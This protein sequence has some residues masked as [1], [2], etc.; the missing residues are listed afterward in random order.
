MC[1]HTSYSMENN[2][3]TYTKP[4]KL[5]CICN[6]CV[7]ENNTKRYST[8]QRRQHYKKHGKSTSTPE[9]PV[10]VEQKVQHILPIP[11]AFV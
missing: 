11:Y 8:T 6:E 4:R 10:F 1:V 9:S 5:R 3:R 7:K 2:I